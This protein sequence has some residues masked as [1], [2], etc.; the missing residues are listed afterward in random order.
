MELME[1]WAGRAGMEN[2]SSNS[3]DLSCATV[4]WPWIYGVQQA[5]RGIQY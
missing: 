5:G 3:N 4:C 2:M 1:V